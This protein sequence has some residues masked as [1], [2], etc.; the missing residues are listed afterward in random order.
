MPY[1]MYI[2]AEGCLAQSKRLETVA[3]NLA[4]VDT[5]GFKRDLA[6]A[7]ARYAEETERGADYPGSGSVNDLGGGVAPM[8]TI[9]DFSQ[10]PLAHTEIPT[11][12]A[13]AGSG[14]FMVQRGPDTLLT[15]AGNFQLNAEGT[16]TTADG[17]PVL[18]ESRTPV[19]IDEALGPWSVSA[20]G[21]IE[22][23]GSLTPLAI[24]APASMGDLVKAGDSLFAP[25]ADP[26]PLAPGERQVRQGFL[27]K[28]GVKPTLEM[29]D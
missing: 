8:A 7:Q 24:V 2:S 29:M 28:S 11:D 19:Q 18:N 12:L 20:N 13:I 14:F 3:N 22:Q 15:R 9:T 17:Y 23:A 6:V 4:N 10:G 25:L 1:G 26:L 21:S 5:A 27:E 16:L